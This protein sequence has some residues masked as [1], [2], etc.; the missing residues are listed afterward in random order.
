LVI[1]EG[2]QSFG[3]ISRV[4]HIIW[5]KRSV[6]AVLGGEFFVVGR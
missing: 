2:S 1:A 3:V 5:N 6:M 4:Y